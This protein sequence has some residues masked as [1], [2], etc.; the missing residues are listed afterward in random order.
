MI[1]FVFIWVQSKSMQMSAFLKMY[2]GYPEDVSLSSDSRVTRTNLQLS[3]PHIED[4]FPWHFA[5]DETLTITAMGQSLLS[6]FPECPI[7]L[8]VKDVLRLQR[9]LEAKL[10]FEDF[11]SRRKCLT[12]IVQLII[13]ESMPFLFAICQKLP[14]HPRKRNRL[15]KT[16]DSQR[17][18]T[19]GESTARKSNRRAS[20]ASTTQIQLSL[21]TESLQLHGQ[22][23]F[24]E[25]SNV[26]LF[27]GIPL[28]QNLEQM[29]EQV[30]PG[31]ADS[32]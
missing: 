14:Q 10:H 15:V 12:F 28:L 7:G 25:E 29:K 6:R 1:Y 31:V 21:C 18:E 9:P 5:F 16:Q 19:E 13:L 20:V 32:C 2:R 26:I 30:K 8:Q 23:L 4:L 27:A 3:S 22:I 11:K 17:S 24:V